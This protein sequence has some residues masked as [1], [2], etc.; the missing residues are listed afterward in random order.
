MPVS[1]SV[2][3]VWVNILILVH[4]AG[5]GGASRSVSIVVEQLLTASVHVFIL[6]PPGPMCGLWTGWG[7]EV[8]VWDPPICQWMGGEV[9]SSSSPACGW[10]V[11]P[12][13]MLTLAKLPLRVVRG[14]QLILEIVQ[15]ESI[16]AIYV[17]SLVLF[18]IANALASLRKEGVRVVWQVR[19]MLNER[20]TRSVH[21]KIATSIARASE[22]VMAISTNEAAVFERLTSVRVIHNCVPTEWSRADV[23]QDMKGIPRVCMASEFHAGKGVSDFWRMAKIIREQYTGVE[24]TLF[25]P[26]PRLRGGPTSRMLRGVGLWND[27]VTLICDMLDEA[28]GLS[29][30]GNVSVIFDHA[31]E[32][33]TYC[34]ATVYVRADRAG[35]PW[36]RDIIEAMWAGV[37]VV[38]TGSSQEFVLDQQT[39]FL[40]PPGNV[41]L[42]ADCV[43]RLLKDPQLHRDMSR[44]ARERALQLFSPA[45]HR[46]KLLAVLGQGT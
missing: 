9:V 5:L 14:R 29:L 24:C 36:G 4:Y 27:K 41:E 7:A 37:P 42:L 1:C 11:V 31:M 40:V 8:L 13:R 28:V 39:G 43:G 34:R 35:C 45:A 22:V 2:G 16:D 17:N 10:N 21:R 3:G 15:R 30:S 38:A 6:S 26:R 33:E 23:T 12:Y 19:E 18:P 32:L 25:T 20:M 44:A 46:A